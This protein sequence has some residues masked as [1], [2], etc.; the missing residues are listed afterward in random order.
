MMGVVL[1]PARHKVHAEHTG[2]A[3]VLL[4]ASSSFAILV[5][6]FGLG[7]GGHHDAPD[8]GPADRPLWLRLH[9]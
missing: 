4:R 8:L 9:Y 5:V 6:R 1:T 7:R 2:V 3:R